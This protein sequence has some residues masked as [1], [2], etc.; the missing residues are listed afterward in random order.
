MNPVIHFEMSASDLKRAA[1]FYTKAFGWQM[2]HL[3]EKWGN[4]A[5]AMTAESDENG[6]KKPGSINGGLYPRTENDPDQHP[7]VVIG[8]ENLRE[9]MKRVEAAGGKVLG[10]PMEI[11]DV[12]WY[13]AFRDTEG[14]RVGMLQPSRP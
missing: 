11:P 9:H 2:Q 12:G 1:D 10:E 5:M 14:N 6:P 4:Y 7:S 8:V 3:G 13:V